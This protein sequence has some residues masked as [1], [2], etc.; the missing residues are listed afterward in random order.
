MRSGLVTGWLNVT[1]NSWFAASCVNEYVPAPVPS[2]TL[3]QIPVPYSASRPHRASFVDG[4]KTSV[5]S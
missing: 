5:G 3:C 4:S 2:E 1:E